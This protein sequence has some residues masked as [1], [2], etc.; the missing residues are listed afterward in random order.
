MP[1]KIIVEAAGT[2]VAG[3]EQDLIE[4]VIDT[5][6]CLPGMFTLLFND[7]SFEYA[8]A[9]TFALGTEVTIKVS[10]FAASATSGTPTEL[11]KGEVTAIEPIFSSKG[12]AM[13]RIRGYDK[14][15][16]LTRSTA[17]KVYAN[18]TD[19][20]IFSAIASEAGLSG[21]ADSA[22]TSL[23]HI[24]MMCYNQTPWDFL[25][26]RAK[27]I[28]AQIYYD[29]TTL[30]L[31]KAWV[32]RGTNPAELTWGKNLNSFEPRIT[33]SGQLNTV[34]AKAWDSAAQA[35][36][37]GTSAAA[38]AAG[39]GLAK[40]G[41]AATQTAF[42]SQATEL[43]T[44]PVNVVAEAT[45]LATSVLTDA[46]SQFIQAE[47][48]ASIAD[49]N[50]VAGRVATI[51]GVGTRFSGTYFITEARHTWSAG[52]YHIEFKAS[53]N[54]SNTFHALIADD[55]PATGIQGIVPAIVVDNAD[56]DSSGKVKVKFPW[57]DDTLTSA[58]ARL[59]APGAGNNY[60]AY[61]L[62]EINDEV[63]VAFEHGDINFPYIVGGIWGKK[64]LP[65]TGTAAI[66]ASS[67]VN[68][69][70]IRSRSGHLVILDD[71]EGSEKIIIQDKTTK[72]SLTFTSSSNALDILADGNINITAKGTMTLKSTGAL[73][74]ESSAAGTIKATGALNVESSAKATFKGT[75]GLDLNT[76]AMLTMKGASAELNSDA[77]TAVKSAGMVQV[78]GALVKIN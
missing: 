75:G 45:N 18:M 57:L 11:F 16:R 1:D 22:F 39:I 25:W 51:K 35:A 10:S 31:K 77:Q 8:D 19:G 34:T 58:W 53:G 27:R 33:A 28:G 4:V 26:M 44:R 13:T 20:A 49:V 50:L 68:Q 78:Q 24:Y 55:Q 70:V 17:T 63:M 61:F 48:V 65:P 43:V 32:T 37:V 76:T 36:L 3:A 67:K 47:G 14:S 29:G 52:S 54:N 62:P 59:C 66:Q 72:N 21:S 40:T 41:G 7:Q 74:I 6:I 69:R 64:L 12:G 5:N 30:Q 9:E 71:T 2:A 38:T 23:T 60:G 15:H 73:S 42:S 56:P 46:E